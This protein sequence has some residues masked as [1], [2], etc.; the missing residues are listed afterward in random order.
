MERE[1]IKEKEM[2]RY[3]HEKTTENQK[4]AKCHKKKRRTN[5]F[6]K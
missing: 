5:R 3:P 2:I 4:M 1:D 6:E